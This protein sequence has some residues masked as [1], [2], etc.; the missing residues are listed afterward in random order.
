MSAEILFFS[1]RVA[2]LRICFFRD[3][4]SSFVPLRSGVAP[5]FLETDYF[6]ICVTQYSTSGLL[7]NDFSEFFVGRRGGVKSDT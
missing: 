6:V 4:S 5:R 7:L 2:S 1:V 3:S